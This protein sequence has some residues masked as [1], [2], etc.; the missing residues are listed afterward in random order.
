VFFRINRQYLVNYH[1]IQKI[2]V[3]SKSRLELDVKGYKERMLVST[4]KTHTFRLWIDK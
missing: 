3:L 1:A 4:A 2:H